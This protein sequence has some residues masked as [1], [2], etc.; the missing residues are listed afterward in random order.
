MAVINIAAWAHSQEE[1]KQVSSLDF[2]GWNKDFHAGS[3]T[4]F[5]KCSSAQ[6]MHSTNSWTQTSFNTYHV[7]DLKWNLQQWL[8]CYFP[9][10]KNQQGITMDLV[11][12]LMS[13]WEVIL[14]KTLQCL[15]FKPISTIMI[16][17]WM[18]ELY[19]TLHSHELELLWHFG[20]VIF[21]CSIHK[22]ST[23][24]PLAVKLGMKSSALHLT[25]RWQ[26][27][28]WMTIVTLLC[29]NKKCRSG[30]SGGPILDSIAWYS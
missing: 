13:F 1:L 16:T 2:T 23:L 5:T 27:L 21:C 3:G 12:S 11:L 14:I 17:K 19:V 29:R 10:T 8:H 25:L 7:Q 20:L 26:L 9:Q 15:L 6:S 30:F 4:T 24:Y 22:N 18:T 28:V